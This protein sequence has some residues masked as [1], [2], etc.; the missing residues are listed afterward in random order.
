MIELNY[1]SLEFDPALRSFGMDPRK[2]L[3]FPF[4]I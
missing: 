1:F 2:L 3:F 4:F